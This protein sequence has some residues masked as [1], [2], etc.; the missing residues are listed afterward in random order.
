MPKYKTADIR[1]T[2]LV[3]H[4]DSGK[5][6]LAEHL[7][8]KAGATSRCGSVKEKT[9]VLD[10]DSDEK[11][12]GHS[13]DVASARCEWKGK[14]INLIDTPGYPD[15]V[16]DVISGLNGGDLALVCISGSAG[17]MTGTRR[18]WK[19]VTDA[20]RPHAI[21]VTKWDQ[22]RSAGAEMVSQIREIFGNSCVPWR[23]P[24]SIGDF[25]TEWIEAVVSS[26]DG[27]LE[28]YME[29]EK[30]PRE[31]I[32]PCSVKAI[33]EGTV[34]PIIF[35]S[36]EQDMG[37]DNLLDFI[38]DRG[39]EPGRVEHMMVQRD[40]PQGTGEHIDPDPAQPFVGI[41]WKL[42]VDRHVGKIGH[43]RVVA[44]TLT[45]GETIINIQEDKKEKIG[46]I[47]VAQGKEQTEVDAA[48]AG[49][50]VILNK[51]DSL[52]VGD[53]L[54]AK[55]TGMIVKTL[56]HPHPMYGLA[57][58]PKNRN[59]EAKISGSMARM[60][61]ECPTFTAVREPS[62]GELVASG[63]TQLHL[64]TVLRRLQER[65]N[66]EVET[67]RP[68]VPYKEALAGRG[69]S[70]YRHKKQTG[71]RGQFAE[72]TLEVSPGVAGGGLQYSW[73]IFGGSIPTNFS[74][75]IEKGIRERMGRGVVAG[76]VMEDVAV[77]IKDGKH[78]DVDS[79]EAAFKTAG[80][81]AFIEAVQK[82]KP[83]ILEPMVK[84]EINIPDK[85]MGDVSG[86]LNT[87][88]G[89]IQGMDQIGDHQVLHTEMPLSEAMDY[90][91]VLIALTSGEGSFTMEPSRYEQVPPQVQ[92]E[93]IAAHKPHEEED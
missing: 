8:H 65:F 3:G 11:E 78:H 38:A 64:D 84:L 22:A 10:Y 61:E 32:G 72:V 59:D 40:D 14:Q 73:D 57:I 60:T 52:K 76:Y 12:R 20:S 85:F 9:T 19:F 24:D 88:R 77:S 51:V 68:K 50:L 66:I 44:G 91:R 45:P 27:L 75:A 49:D 7:L 89:R 23:A 71:G 26:D 48:I 25:E 43:V 29:G 37:I 4:A 2:V 46:H 41:V 92:Q 21:V 15:F 42:Q 70:R 17:V 1:N 5:T 81:R 36:C 13:V 86:D 82:A 62:T 67:H 34:I 79:S 87:R 16:G 18:A 55:D 63:M 35:T 31:E 54:A 30:I 6:T 83:I 33:A 74:S 58:T 53:T 93:L 90:S 39:S 28:R 69:D 80:G 47:F 56:P